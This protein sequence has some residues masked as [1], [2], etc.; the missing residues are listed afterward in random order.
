M[1][2]ENPN[3]YQ[4]TQKGIKYAL[5]KTYYNKKLWSNFNLMTISFIKGELS[6]K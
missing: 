4:L 3:R 5:A 1:S 2:K 6:V